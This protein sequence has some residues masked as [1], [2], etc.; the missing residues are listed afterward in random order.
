MKAIVL[1]VKNGYSAL[2]RE[3]GVVIK[4]RG[5]LEVGQEIQV[6]DGAAGQ[7]LRRLRAAVAAVAIVGVMTASGWT[8]ENALAYSYATLDVGSTSIEYVLNRRG[9]VIG[10]NALNDSSEDSA[11]EILGQVKRQ[12]LS[13]AIAGTMDSF[14]SEEDSYA[15]VSVCS[16]NDAKARDLADSVDRAMKDHP[17]DFHAKTASPEERRAARDEKMSTGRWQ[18]KRDSGHT[19]DFRNGDMDDLIKDDAHRPPAKDNGQGTEPDREVEAQPNGP[20]NGRPGDAGPQGQD[21]PR[22]EGGG[23]GQNGGP[24]S[25]AKPAGFRE[26][27][28]HDGPQAPAQP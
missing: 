18:V 21:G 10:V 16:P 4:R 26:E 22:G 3:D 8:Y 20:E 13:D 19:G 14:D 9:Q 28:P 5:A 7:G 23:P 2:L 12:E 25:G 15:Q 27:G 1:E 6:S 11:E 17:F 24:D